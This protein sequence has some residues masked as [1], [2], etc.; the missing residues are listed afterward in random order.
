MV[1]NGK[2]KLT[3]KALKF[4]QAL[5][6]VLARGSEQTTS[7]EK[8]WAECARIGLIDPGK[9]GSARSQFSEYRSK[10]VVANCITV[11]GRTVWI[12]P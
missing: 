10:L 9:A 3:G 1:D 5:Q 7:L 6:A 11:D 8:W 4:F 12:N 2:E